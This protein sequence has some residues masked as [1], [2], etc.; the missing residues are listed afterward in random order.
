MVGRVW[1]LPET[2]L[3]SHWLNPPQSSFRIILTD[4]IQVLLD[5]RCFADLRLPGQLFP[6]LKLYTKN[7]IHHCPAS[8]RDT[9]VFVVRISY[10]NYH[11]YASLHASA[12]S[13][14]N[15]Y[16]RILVRDRG[17]SLLHGMLHALDDQYVGIL[18]GPL[19][20]QLCAE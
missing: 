3:N 17:S 8:H 16:S 4:E 14:R 2:S 20:G 12:P 5:Q 9:L 15:V 13:G 18:P 6:A 19:S 11:M 7:P 1:G 10:C